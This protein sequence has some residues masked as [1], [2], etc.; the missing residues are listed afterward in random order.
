MFVLSFY[1]V[2]KET[3]AQ[4]SNDCSYWGS[5]VKLFFGH[6]DWFSLILINYLKYISRFSKSITPFYLTC[7]DLTFCRKSDK[8]LNT[9]NDSPSI[10]SSLASP[11]DF[12]VLHLGN[13]THKIAV[14]RPRIELNPPVSF[15]DMFRKQHF[16]TFFTNHEFPYVPNYNY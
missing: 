10:I 7:V 2:L 13:T 4:Y 1:I 16:F 15:I 8:G 5:T 12:L 6:C 14:I 9:I 3:L 11:N